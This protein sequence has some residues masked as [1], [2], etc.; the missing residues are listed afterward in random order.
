V[1][2]AATPCPG[3]HTQSI[4]DRLAVAVLRTFGRFETD[5]SINAE[6]MRHML[7]DEA[8]HRAETQESPDR[9]KDLQLN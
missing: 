3:G 2:V 5:L 8:R 7:K 9:L 6:T 1:R 4:E